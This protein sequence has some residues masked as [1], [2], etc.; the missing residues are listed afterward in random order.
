VYCWGANSVGQIGDGST[1]DRLIPT[2]V[3][4]PGGATVAAITGGSGHTCAITSTGITYCWGANDKGQIGIGTATNSTT[5]VVV[6][7]PTG[8]TFTAIDAGTMD[9]CAINSAGA[10]YC[11]GW[12]LFG[13]LGICDTV[14][15]NVPTRVSGCVPPT[16]TSTSTITSTP[17]RTATVTVRIHSPIHALPPAPRRWCQAAIHGATSPRLRRGIQPAVPSTVRVMLTVGEV[18]KV[19]HSVTVRQRI[20]TLRWPLRCPLG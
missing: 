2:A 11:W 13:E 19:A 18:I 1:T 16:P 12:N 4:M 17:T 3:T 5:P 10:A 8:V 6:T 20:A 15:R 7:M 9:V 14:D